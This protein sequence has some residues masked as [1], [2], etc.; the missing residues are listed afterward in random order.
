MKTFFTFRQNDSCSILPL[1]QLCII[2]R[3]PLSAC[4]LAIKKIA[5]HSEELKVILWETV[6]LIPSLFH[7]IIYC[8]ADEAGLKKE[9]GGRE[10]SLSIKYVTNTIQDALF[11]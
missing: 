2:A 10:H 1:Y 4:S 3:D 7:T 6:I 9:F 8:K 5:L 11:I